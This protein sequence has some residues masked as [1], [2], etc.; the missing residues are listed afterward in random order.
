MDFEGLFCDYV[1]V[2]NF[3]ILAIK[4]FAFRIYLSKSCWRA[5]SVSSFDVMSSAP[6]NAAVP[7]A[8][9]KRRRSFCFI[10]VVASSLASCF[11]EAGRLSTDKPGVD[12]IHIRRLQRFVFSCF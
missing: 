9:P 3:W 7:S 11:A 5:A 4:E 8:F 10:T 12:S 2:G 6:C 1:C